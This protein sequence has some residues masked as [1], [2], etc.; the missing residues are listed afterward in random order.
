[1][2][3]RTLFSPDD[4]RR[5]ENMTLSWQAMQAMQAM[6]GWLHHVDCA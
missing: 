2:S 3:C 6:Q 1:M 4:E 5:P